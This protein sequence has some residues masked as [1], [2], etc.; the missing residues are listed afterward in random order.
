MNLELLYNNT[1]ILDS[2]Q[3]FPLKKIQNTMP[4]LYINVAV[5][6]LL[7][8]PFVSDCIMLYFFGLTGRKCY[9]HI[10]TQKIRGF[11]VLKYEPKDLTLSFRTR[12][13]NTLL[14]LLMN[15]TF[16]IKPNMIWKKD[17]NKGYH[18]GLPV[19]SISYEK[20][21]FGPYYSGFHFNLLSSLE[22][23]WISVYAKKKTV[24]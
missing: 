23:P 1:Y 22:L 18:L 8:D 5:K 9:Q 2:I 10:V 15:E 17:N 3:R 14:L 6:S 16:Y 12:S 20:D 19:L 21:P 13:L 7:V 4:Y 11:P 24:L